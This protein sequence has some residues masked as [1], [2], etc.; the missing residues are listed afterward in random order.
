MA[1]R[2]RWPRC[3]KVF[4]RPVTLNRHVRVLLLYLRHLVLAAVFDEMY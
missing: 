3:S 4:F 2:L 1:L